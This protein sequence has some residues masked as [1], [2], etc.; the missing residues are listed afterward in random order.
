MDRETGQF[1]YG[2]EHLEQSL[3]ILFTTFIGER[4]FRRYLGI[5]GSLVDRPINRD[6]IGLWA[7][8]FAEALRYARERRFS[9]N[10]VNLTQVDRNGVATLSIEGN[11]KIKINYDKYPK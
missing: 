10:Q 5:D 6:F 9:L 11:I 1:I 3:R 4:V 2:D 7:Y 8:T